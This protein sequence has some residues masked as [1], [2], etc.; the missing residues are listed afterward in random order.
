MSIKAF[1]GFMP[2]MTCRGFQ[3]EEGKEYETDRA[4]LCEAGFHACEH[5]LDCF[6][7]YEPG[8]GSVYH[9][10]E[11]DGVYGGKIPHGAVAQS[12]AKETVE[13]AEAAAGARLDRWFCC[14]N[15]AGWRGGLRARLLARFPAPSR[16]ERI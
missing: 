13:S 3:Y 14:W 9:E 4:K 6:G 11:L 5:P 1:K 2:D 10:V 8:V 12:A 15:D 16:W 7:Y